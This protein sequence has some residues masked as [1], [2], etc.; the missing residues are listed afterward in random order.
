[1]A[2]VE[3]D[4]DE[5]HQNVRYEY[6]T[7]IF[8]RFSH[9]VFSSQFDRIVLDPLYSIPNQFFWVHIILYSIAATSEIVYR[10]H[11]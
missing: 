9:L 1:M 4:F 7:N 2:T 3:N 10:T 5:S 8:R 6:C 11:T